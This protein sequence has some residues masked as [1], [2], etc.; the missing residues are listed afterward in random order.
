M[1]QQAT[2]MYTQTQDVYRFGFESAGALEFVNEYS[3]LAALSAHLYCFRRTQECMPNYFD[4]E[5]RRRAM[6]K[7]TNASFSA[8]IGIDWADTK[9]DVCIQAAGEEHR[10]FTCLPHKAEEIEAWALDL[11]QRFGGQMAVAL[12]LSKGPLV[13][14]LQKYNFFVIFPVHPSTLAKYR[15]PQGCPPRTDTLTLN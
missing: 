4:L 13:Y 6:T 11:H 2:N 9:H 10:T 5:L 15:T 3:G 8:Y 1:H 14:A 7:Q 12:E